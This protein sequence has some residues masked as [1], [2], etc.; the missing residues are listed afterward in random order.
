MADPT[1]PTPAIL[2]SL[3]TTTSPPSQTAWQPDQGTNTIMFAPAILSPP[4]TNPSQTAWQPDQDAFVAQTPH[5]HGSLDRHAPPAIFP[6]DT[7]ADPHAEPPVHEALLVISQGPS[8]R[9]GAVPEEEALV[10]QAP[11][12]IS[13]GPSDRMGVAL[14]SPV[15]EQPYSFAPARGLDLHSELDVKHAAAQGGQDQGETG[16]EGGEW[17]KRW[18]VTRQRRGT[19]AKNC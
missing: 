8:G 19:K 14:L 17:R 12:V 18:Q 1:M 6:A 16:A 2:S 7:Q 15:D 10:H 9:M 13:S 3:T 11:S 5:D 4:T